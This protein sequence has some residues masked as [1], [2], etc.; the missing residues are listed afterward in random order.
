[1]AFK[2]DTPLLTLSQ[3]QEWQNERN[4]LAA[5]M[6]AMNERLARLDRKL[7]AAKVFVPDAEKEA[8]K[9]EIE[10]LEAHAASDSLSDVVLIAVG[11]LGGSPKPAAIRRRVAQLNP[12][13]GAK[14]AE[15]S[16]YFYTV[17]G[18]HLHKGRLVKHGGGYRLAK[19][20]PNGEAGAVAGAS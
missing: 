5:E 12:T 19:P 6:A 17:L 16:S 13:L 14:L 7:E 18:R 20:S 9:S 4:Q 1:M 15:S 3:I 10:V 11:T 8:E 2:F